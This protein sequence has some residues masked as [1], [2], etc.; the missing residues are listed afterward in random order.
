MSTMAARQV[1]PPEDTRG[2]LSLQTDSTASRRWRVGPHCAAGVGGGAG[3]RREALPGSAAAAAPGTPPRGST[4][5]LSNLGMGHG[6]KRR[7][8]LLDAAEA[9]LGVC[10]PAAPHNAARALDAH[11]AR[12]WRGVCVP[13]LVRRATTSSMTPAAQGVGGLE[14]RAHFNPHSRQRRHAY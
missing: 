6:A 11:A 2:L 14:L 10:S 13:R 8:Q 7:L 3:V 9:V 4:V 12:D 1:S 5:I